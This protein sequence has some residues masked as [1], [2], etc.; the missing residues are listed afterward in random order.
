M[1]GADKRELRCVWKGE[2]G[3]FTDQEEILFVTEKSKRGRNRAIDKSR[4]LVTR[5]EESTRRIRSRN[6][7]G[8]ASFEGTRRQTE[9]V[10]L[11]GLTRILSTLD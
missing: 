1:M 8:S 2:D 3:L 9:K 4:Q 7:G 5:L 6:R 10:C 11:A